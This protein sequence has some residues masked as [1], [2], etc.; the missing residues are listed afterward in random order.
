MLFEYNPTTNESPSYF[1]LA[2][3]LEV[4]FERLKYLDEE[5]NFDAFCEDLSRDLARRLVYIV[6]CSFFIN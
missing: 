2:F 1:L 3:L 5:V 4:E 6:L